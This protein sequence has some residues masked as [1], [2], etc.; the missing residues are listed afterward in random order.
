[1]DYS[2]IGTA[3]T[4]YDIEQVE[5]L[6]GPQGTRY[7]SNA[8]AGL[9]NLQSKAATKKLSG[10]IET[11]VGNQDSQEIAGYVSGPVSD[12]LLFRVSAQ[13]YKTD[14]FSNN[15]TINRPT[16]FKDES[17]LRGKLAWQISD[18]SRLDINATLI[19]VDNGYDAFS[20]DN[21][22]NTLSDEPGFDRQR[23]RA[24]SARYVTDLDALSVEVLAST[25]DSDIEYG[26]DEDW[27]YVGFH[28]D[29][30]SATDQYLRDHDN[31][32]LE[33]RF[34][35][36]A[37]STVEWVAGIYSLQQQVNLERTYTY[38]SGPFNSD[39]SVDRTA[40]YADASFPLAASLFLDTG[41]RVEQ[42][43]GDYSD[44]DTLDF[45]PDETMTGG[46]LNLRYLMS[47]STLLYAGVSRGYKTGGFNTDG[48]LPAD[49]REFDAEYLWNYETGV[50]T[51]WPDA[52]LS[53][54]ASLFYMD[55]DDVQ[56]SSSTLRLRPDGSTEFIDYTGNAAAG[57]NYGMEINAQWQISDV[58]SLSGNLGLLKSEYED[59]V[60]SAGDDLVGREQAHAPNYQFSVTGAWQMTAALSGSVTLQGKDSY[61]FSDSHND[62]S[63]AYETLNAQLS[64]K[65]EHWTMQLWGR[66]LTDQDYAVR[67]FHFGNDPRDGYT[68]KSYIQLGEDRRYGVTV[69]YEF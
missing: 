38:L 15:L 40:L 49:L 30:Y 3:S 18:T 41:I 55:R 24:L 13:S 56:I 10:G 22:R 67:G 17:T 8:L 35:S 31:D 14:G 2:G 61:Y 62:K 16:N 12:D 21:V 29:E 25:A 27:V 34:L 47:D 65:L 48:S 64:Y 19:D 36:A 42:F 33:L 66:N 28:P 37:G 57:N 26:Y 51:F 9:I 46:R 7:G 44:S 39:Y 69:N 54:Q 68:G 6:L 63:D 4:L 58:F 60:N 23:S 50:K 32:S 43:S 20:L 1:V 59:F 45:G 53:L 52:G 5:V 11:Q